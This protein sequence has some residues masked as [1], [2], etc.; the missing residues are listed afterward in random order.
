MSSVLCSSIERA[1]E[2]NSRVYDMTERRRQNPEATQCSSSL[3]RPTSLSNPLACLQQHPKLTRLTISSSM[4]M[5]TTLSSSL[6]D[7]MGAAAATPI[8]TAAMDDPRTPLYSTFIG[9][10]RLLNAI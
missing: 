5:T 4:A 1:G 8:S 6:Q 7:A 9:K 3:D 2:T 10:K